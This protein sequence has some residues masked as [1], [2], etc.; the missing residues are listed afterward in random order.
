MLTFTAWPSDPE[1][2]NLNTHSIRFVASRASMDADWTNGTLLSTCLHVG[3]TVVCL[4]LPVLL[5]S[6]Y[7][8]LL[9][10]V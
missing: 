9:P 10:F 4:I 8:V 3:S 2:E 5:Q 1:Q 6:F 7:K